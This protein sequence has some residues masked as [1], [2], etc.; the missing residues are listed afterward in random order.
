MQAVSAGNIVGYITYC[1]HL[2]LKNKCGI[3]TR[4]LTKEHLTNKFNVPI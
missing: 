1:M 3:A 2:V 4:N